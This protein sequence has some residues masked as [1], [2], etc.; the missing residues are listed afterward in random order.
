MP[1]KKSSTEARAPQQSITNLLPETPGGL[2]VSPWSLPWNS[3]QFERFAKSKNRVMV[4]RFLQ[5]TIP[6]LEYCIKMLPREAVGKGISLKSESKNPEF[7]AS[8]T[9]LFKAWADSPAVDL[10]KEMTFY[11]LQPRWLSALL[12]DGECFQLA[13][14]DP[15]GSGWSLQDRSKRAIQ[16]QTFL[17]DQLTDGQLT[18]EEQNAQRW[19][20]GLQY[21][22]LDQLV[23]VRINQEAGS[24]IGSSTRFRDLPV[25]N[26]L[27]GRVLFHLKD[28]RRFN[29]YHGDP[30][31]FASNND[32]LDY[33]D[34]KALRKHSAKVR[35]ALLGATTTNDGKPPTAIVAAQ[36]RGTGTSTTN[37][38]GVTT[39]DNGKRFMEI[40][41]GAVMIP[42][43]DKES[44]NF[45]NST[46]EAIPFGQ[47]LSDLLTPFIFTLGYP[48]EWI[49][50]RGKVGGTEYRG[51]LEQV[52]SAHENLRLLLHPLLQWTWEKVI[53]NAIATGPLAKFADVADWAS[54][55]FIA[56][57]DP[58]VDLGRDRKAD[59]EDIDANLISPCDLIESRT[60]KDGDSIQRDAILEKLDL[61][62]FAVEEGKK[63]GIPASLAIIQ[64]IP[65]KKLQAASG[66]LTTLSPQTIAGELAG[67]DAPVIPDIEG[68]GD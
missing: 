2:R 55:E 26:A 48:P 12:G 51:L 53:G 47:I 23:T 7:R 21:N 66:I 59:H 50:L 22:G 42:L 56:D 54:V 28:N 63:R 61:M 68:E 5:E 60:G 64:A 6:Q 33:L 17:R 30:F 43:A 35:A 49:F 39:T 36:S 20:N 19:L 9:E 15:Q 57:V 31:I 3:K 34:L 58:T 29:Q 27:G 32:L 46:T 1:R 65:S 11:E 40:E 24:A 18:A 41:G 62:Q 10:R 16:M 37:E 52:R 13:V 8:A 45:F 44:F 4:S 14:I 67:L 38:A 25:Y